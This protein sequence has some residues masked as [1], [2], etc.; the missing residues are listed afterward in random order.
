[1]T[2]PQSRFLLACLAGL[3][4]EAALAQTDGRP[5]HLSLLLASDF[6]HNGLSQTGSDPAL[7]L[8][9]DFEHRS[10]F[11]TGGSIRNAE[12]YADERSPSQRKS[13]ANLYLGF[14]WRRDRWSGSVS[15]TRYIYPG[16]SSRYDYSQTAAGFSYR[17]R[18]FFSY[19][20]SNDYFS[21]GQAA[22][23]YRAGV[24]LPWIWNLQTSMN[25]GELQS[26]DVFDVSYS[27]WDIGVSKVVG[28]F[29]LDLRYHDDTYDRSTS[30]GESGGD[31]WVLSVSYAISPR[32]R[33]PD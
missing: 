12:F 29:A 30:I 32:A 22:H 20:R 17:N 25:V 31:R 19:A 18:Y 5:V 24:A 26:D 4:G 1:M 28:R 11:F 2:R 13:S 15:A 14:L 23:E 27:F 7:R 6:K 8:S 33:E 21:I 10:G 3:L 9:A 16:S